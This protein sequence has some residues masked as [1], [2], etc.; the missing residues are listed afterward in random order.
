MADTEKPGMSATERFKRRK[1]AEAVP[2]PAVAA[3]EQEV[4]EQVVLEE[5][6]PRRKILIAPN[7]ILTTKCKE[8]DVV[9]DN[10]VA[11]A[12]DME[13]FLK[14]PPPMK[15]RQ[16]GL[17]APQMGVGVRLISCMLNPMARD[18]VNYNIVSIVNPRLVYV[19]KMHLVPET[20]SSLPGRDFMVKRGKVVK[21][22]GEL[23]DGTPKTF[24]GHD[25]V[26]QMF[27]HELDHLD[28]LLLNELSKR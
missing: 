8:V 16:I 23:L 6:V 25:M 26:A 11:L 2:K 15:V 22:K 3:P 7:S 5:A 4:P 20:C 24:K 9:N 18:P 19:K 1:A 13:D 27:Q 10:I 14:N 28:G 12:H 17:A 21:V